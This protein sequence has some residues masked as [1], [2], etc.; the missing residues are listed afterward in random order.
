MPTSKPK[1][2]ET[3]LL[4]QEKEDQTAMVALLIT[5]DSS[6]EEKMLSKT[7]AS[8]VQTQEE[9]GES[10][11]LFLDGVEELLK[12]EEEVSTTEAGE[13]AEIKLLKLI[14]EQILKSIRTFTSEGASNEANDPS[15][16]SNQS[17]ITIHYKITQTF[18]HLKR[19]SKYYPQ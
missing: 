2:E 16:L 12:L 11:E 7:E 8:R 15:T 9:D 19:I 3:D 4:L 6:M 5:L 18:T 13:I 10:S 1:L 14:L 17:S